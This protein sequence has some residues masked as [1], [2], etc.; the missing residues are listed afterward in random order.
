MFP[1]LHVVQRNVYYFVENCPTS[2][3]RNFVQLVQWCMASYEKEN[4]LRRFGLGTVG[5]AFG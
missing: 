1:T 5:F 2:L 3:V 4:F